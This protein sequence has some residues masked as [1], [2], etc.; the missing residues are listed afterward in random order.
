M[1]IGGD[2]AGGVQWERHVDGEDDTGA[3]VSESADGGIDEVAGAGGEGE[4]ER[5]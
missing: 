4:D 3:S 5:V 1:L 2:A